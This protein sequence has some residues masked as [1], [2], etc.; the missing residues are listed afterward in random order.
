MKEFQKEQENR[1]HSRPVVAIHVD[2]KKVIRFQSVRSCAKYLERNPA[3]VTK[4]CQGV[5]HTCNKHRLFYEESFEKLYG[6]VSKV[7]W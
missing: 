5:W 4:V 2:E 1:G 7:D 6:K 3:A